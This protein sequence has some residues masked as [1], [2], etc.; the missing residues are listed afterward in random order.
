LIN[1]NPTDITQLTEAELTSILE[2]HNQCYW[3]QGEPE[4]SEALTG[5]FR[6]EGIETI[7][8]ITYDK[9]STN[10]ETITLAVET[11]DAVNK[12]M[13][14]FDVQ[15]EGNID[16]G[17]I[18]QQAREQYEIAALD[19]AADLDSVESFADMI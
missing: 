4:I 13:E 11:K 18:E 12:S 16:L 5:Y 2:H 15:L 8:G 10:G 3:E 19:S 17:A 1:P 7:S 6:D 9:I 14:I